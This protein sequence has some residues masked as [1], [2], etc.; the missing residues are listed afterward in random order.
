MIYHLQNRLQKHKWPQNLL[1]SPQCL[2]LADPKRYLLFVNKKN[3]IYVLILRTSSIT[4]QI[5]KRSKKNPRIN[6]QAVF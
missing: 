4:A 1:L 2:Y 6:P 5:K 3:P